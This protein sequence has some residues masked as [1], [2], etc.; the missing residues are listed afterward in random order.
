MNPIETILQ[1]Y[2][3]VILDGALATELERRGAD[4]KDKLWS[5]KLL[6]ENPGLIK[7]VHTDYFFAGADCAT[8]ASYQATVE[9][10]MQRGLSRKESIDLIQKSVILAQEARDEFWA[11]EINRIGRPRPF[12]AAS[13][14]PY[15]AF[16]ADGSEYR[17]DY[18]LTES[19]LI[20][21]HRPRMEALI[22]AGADMLACET[23]PCFVEA[24][25][26]AQLLEEF[27]S[28]SAWISFSA[29]DGTHISSGE[30]FSDCTRW[31]DQF[32]QVAAVG[33]NC[34]SPKFI[35]SLIKETR[36]KTTKPILVYPNSGES[37]NANK[38]D[39]DGD[40]CEAFGESAKEW[41]ASGARI[42]GGCCR[43][44]PDDIRS[45]AAWAR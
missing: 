16:L 17:G 26:I 13:V 45:I 18:G 39:W 25:A 36:D 37:Y 32:P 15:G 4:L 20:A 44:T 40:T 9:G 35:S 28:V 22:A 33:I 10:F 23:I 11:N 43:T 29:K 12:I 31:L 2:P 1:K 30:R 7:Q 42:I 38:H 21:F 24:Q 5:A 19:E 41:Y 27:P 8:T 6:I 34:T 3:A 14:G